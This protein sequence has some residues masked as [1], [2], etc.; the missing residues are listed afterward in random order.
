MSPIMQCSVAGDPGWKWGQDG[1]CY[2]YKPG[3]EAGSKRAKAA[4]QRQA[5]A[6]AFA[7]GHGRKPIFT[8]GA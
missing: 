8:E 1:K 4:A 7:R 6:V 5:L 3:D 2:V